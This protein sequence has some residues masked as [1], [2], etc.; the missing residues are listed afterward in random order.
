VVKKEAE[1]INEQ[2]SKNR[3]ARCKSGNIKRPSGWG[4]LLFEPTGGDGGG[5]YDQQ[6]TITISERLLH[7]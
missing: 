5:L 1:K 4:V 7:L 3:E 6:P 2:F